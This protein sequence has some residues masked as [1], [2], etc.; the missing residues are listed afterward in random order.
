MAKARKGGYQS[1]ARWCVRLA[2]A[3]GVVFLV[4]I[5]T[6]IDYWWATALAGPWDDPKGDVLVVLTGSLL[7]DRTIGMNSYWR[8]VYAAHAFLDDHFQQMIISGGVQGESVAN[9]IPMRDFVVAQGVPAQAV[10]LETASRSTRESALQVAKMLAGKRDQ[11]AVLLTSD[12][13]M[14]RSYRAFRRAGAAVVPRPIPDARKRAGSL[15]DRSGVFL[16]LV[17][18]TTKIA[19]YWSRGWL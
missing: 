6:P 8:A 14:F 3:I 11:R 15:A 2:A 17:R 16:E 12:Y 19:Y 9:A 10:E 18:E 13:H 1:V 7:D 4:I 5:L